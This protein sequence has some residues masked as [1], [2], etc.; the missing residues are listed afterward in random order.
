VEGRKGGKHEFKICPVLRNRPCSP[1]TLR[2]PV[3]FWGLKNMSFFKSLSSCFK[4]DLHRNS[5]VE[6]AMQLHVA[7][8]IGFLK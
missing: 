5:H 6:Q 3:N 2:P 7:I 4:R 8:A 1:A